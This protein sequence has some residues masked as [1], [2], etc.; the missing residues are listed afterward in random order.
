MT[1]Y[2]GNSI[3]ELFSYWNCPCFFK[4]YNISNQSINY[5]FDL[6]NPL[7]IT[8][9]KKLIKPLEVATGLSA[10]FCDKSV[11]GHFAIELARGGERGKLE[12]KRLGGVMRSLPAF[13]LLLGNDT[14]NNPVAITLNDM[15]HMLVAGTTGSGK[16]VALN[17]YILELCCYNQQ[18]VGVVLID[19]KRNEFC[20][21]EGLPQLL[22]DVVY[23]SDT[24]ESVLGWLVY[25][26]E[27]RYVILQQQGNLNGYK[28]IFV[29]IDELTD[30]VMQN[31]KCKDLLVRLL[32]KSRACGIHIVVAT[33]SPRAKVLDG[34]MLA[35]LPTRIALTCSNMRESML[36]L[37]HKG[38]ENLAGK[39]DALVKL[40]NSVHEKHIQIPYISNEDIAKLIKGR[41]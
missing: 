40:P 18:G 27:Q 17:S 2:D 41:N 4:Q 6:A 20:K 35:N 3:A 8:K 14:E 25:E 38:A 37:G 5:A 39:G 29:V 23:D 24:A 1:I 21:F 26:M 19:L 7:D 15:P 12:L 36:I 30:L 33:Q 16:S 22:V 13:S 31:S 10:S 11:N 28:K 32:Q 9:I 34:L